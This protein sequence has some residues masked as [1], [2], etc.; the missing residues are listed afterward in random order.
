MKVQPNVLI[1]YNDSALFEWPQFP[2]EQQLTISSIW[3]N[4][5]L[6]QM[7]EQQ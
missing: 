2:F 4:G 7:L 1:D 5:F 6:L 3:I